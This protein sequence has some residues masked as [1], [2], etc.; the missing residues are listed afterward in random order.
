MVQQANNT[1]NMTFWHVG[2]R[3]NDHILNNQRADDGKQIVV[4]LARQLSWSHFIILFPLKTLDEK[5]FY[6]Q[7]AI[8]ENWGKR[9]LRKQ[10]GPKAKTACGH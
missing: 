5:L 6:A 8:N 1:V 3:I 7:K 9:E 10:I 2:K 4:T